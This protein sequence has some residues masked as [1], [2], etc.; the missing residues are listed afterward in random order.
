VGYWHRGGKRDAEKFVEL[1]N[2]SIRFIRHVAMPK[3]I[4]LQ[5]PDFN[6]G[7]LAEVSHLRGEEVISR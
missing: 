6:S 2:F 4:A 7:F 1:A 3:S 5:Y